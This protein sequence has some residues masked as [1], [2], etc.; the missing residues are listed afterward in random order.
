MCTLNMCR[1]TVTTLNQSMPWQSRKLSDTVG[2]Y[3][4]LCACIVDLVDL[5]DLVT[6]MIIV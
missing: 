4:G 2:V 3:D 1:D 6:R 5:M